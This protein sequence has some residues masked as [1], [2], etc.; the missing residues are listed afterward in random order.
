MAYLMAGIFVSAAMW[1]CLFNWAAERQACRMRCKYLESILQKDIAWFDT[2][3]PASLPTRLV[4]EVQDIQEAI[5]S[6]LGLLIQCAGQFVSG[7][8][9]AFAYGW[10][11]T[12]LMCISLPIVTFAGVQ[13]SRSVSASAKESQEFYG[14]AFAVAEEGLMAIRTVAAF[15]GESRQ[16]ARYAAQLGEAKRG[17]VKAGN[18]MAVAFSLM[19]ANNAG[20]FALAFWYGS[21]YEIAENGKTGA[22][23]IMVFF[24][25]LMGVMVA[26]QAGNPVLCIAKGCAA[27]SNMHA[28]MNAKCRIESTQTSDTATCTSISSITFENVTFKYPSRPDV[29]ILKGLS[30]SIS[31]GQKVAFVGESGSGKS[32]AIQLLERFYDPDSGD[33]K[34]N[35]ISLR[36]FSPQAWRRMVGYVGQEPVLFATTV[37]D[38]IKGGRASI[39]DEEAYEAARQAQAFE[40]IDSMPK[41]FQTYVGGGGSQV[42]GGQKQRIAIA[43]ALACKPEL[44]LL[45]EATSALDNKSEKMVQATLDTLQAKQEDGKGAAFTTISIAHRLSTIRNSDVIFVFKFG[46]VV[47]QGSHAELMEK[48]GEYYILVESQT[49][50]GDEVEQTNE[51]DVKKY[52]STD[53]PDGQNESQGRERIYSDDALKTKAA[54]QKERA[55]EL[56]KAKFSTPK[57]RLF[58]MAKPQW[59]IFPFALLCACISGAGLPW[60]GWFFADAMGYMYIPVIDLMLENMLYVIWAF[61]VLAVAAG[62]GEFGKFSLFTYI[63]EC[64]TLRL[65]EVGFGTIIKQHIGFFD[66]PKNGAPALSAMLSRQTMLVSQA[67]GI[68]LGNTCG[69]FFSLVC[70]IILG[71]M[72]M[73][74]LSLI[75]LACV[76]VLMV[77]MGII[78]K[79]LM[80]T[81]GNS[82]ADD[83]LVEASSHATEGILNIRTVRALVAE[84]HSL[85]L[86]V[87]NMWKLANKKAGGSWKNGLALGVGNAMFFAVYGVAFG[88]GAYLADQEEYATN[89]QAMFKS[90]FCIM[91]GAQGAGM[92]MA[93]MPNAAEALVAAADVF[94]VI[95]RKSEIDPVEPTGKHQSL[96]DGTIEMRNVK[97]FYPHRPELE[98]LREINFV[99]KKGQ[100]VAF[101][102]PS[103][104]GKSTILQLLQRFYDPSSGAVLVGGTDLKDF[105]V[106]WWRQQLGFVGQEP[107]LFDMTLEENVRYGKEG[108]TREEVEEAARVANMDYV[109]TG[110]KMAWSDAVG[111][112]GGQLSGGQKQRAAIA[113]AI[114]RNP[115]VLILDEATSALD[116]R[117]EGVV[118]A[119]LDKAKEGRTTFAIAHRL[120][121]IQNSDVIFVLKAGKI[122]E[123][124]RHTDLL[125]NQGL[126]W[127]LASQ[128][129]PGSTQ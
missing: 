29:Q 104:C 19:F 127:H 44:L 21:F 107:V 71:F 94:R 111:S 95:D 17:G 79:L 108:A 38:N 113:R 63:Q 114:I 123:H 76:P 102:G 115:S 83:E 77:V 93:F 99:V 18:M 100:S 122:A 68:S 88:Y 61:V 106:A 36:T 51:S 35:D 16:V 27:A 39:T 10:R 7:L 120:S 109:L 129:A 128:H 15:G 65:R 72:G 42:S 67:I 32:T 117:S 64:L 28:I 25:A 116:N 62:I 12:L 73:W 54:I 75:I 112:K 24:A 58:A 55:D 74:Q 126:Y 50:G 4:S 45:D 1:Q 57:G 119:A 52:D 40:F 105:N 49:A 13:M 97:F 34:I 2:R 47:E 78:M 31:K 3:N 86:Y 46:Q 70:G 22:D 98:V 91:F 14:K 41:K 9:V 23:V 20:M 5:G 33:V 81:G 96:G 11:M 87:R 89:P 69:S 30:L 85:D 110:G 56:K 80:P 82:P 125:A 66:D 124:G 92:A 43:R 48:K 26:N 84:G 121:T 103:G 6:N 8:C 37:L 59:H 101:V 53:S 90:L 118:Q 60:N